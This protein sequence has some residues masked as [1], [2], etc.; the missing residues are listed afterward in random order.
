MGRAASRIVSVC[1]L[2]ALLS[3]APLPSRAEEKAESGGLVR[4]V[5]MVPLVDRGRG[6]IL[7]TVP[8][9][10]EIHASTDTAKNFLTERMATLQ[11]SYM[12]AAYG[13]VF[14]DVDYGTLTHVLTEAVD[15]VAG[16]DL[17]DQYTISIQVNVKPK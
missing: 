9:I 17:K 3:A 15:S 8:I 11:D 16:E 7:K 1:C 4:H 6:S 5:I 13:K 10:I 2:L 14:S 12:Q